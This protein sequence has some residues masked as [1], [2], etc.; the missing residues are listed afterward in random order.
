MIE[1]LWDS[2]GGQDEDVDKPFRLSANS[3]ALGV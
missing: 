3:K 2:G 1:S